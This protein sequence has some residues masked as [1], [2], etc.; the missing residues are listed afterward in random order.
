MNPR[1]LRVVSIALYRRHGHIPA[2]NRFRGS[3]WPWSTDRILR[4]TET[5]TQFPWTPVNISGL[6]ESRNLT[7]A[8]QPSPSQPH[9][10]Q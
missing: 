4:S 2:E 6:S 3:L 5:Q 9:P 10:L 8:P 7:R 1:F